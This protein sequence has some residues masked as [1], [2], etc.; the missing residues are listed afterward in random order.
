MKEMHVCSIDLLKVDIEGAEKE[1]FET[2]DWI[3]DVRCLM[4]ELHDG[5]KPGC[6]EVVGSVMQEFSKVRRGETNLYVRG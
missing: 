4:I 1:A 6:S 2:C 3:R 5:F